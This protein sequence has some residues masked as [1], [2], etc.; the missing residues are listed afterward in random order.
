METTPQILKDLMAYN[1]WANHRILEQ[2]AGLDEGVLSA[3]TR[4]SFDSIVATLYHI[5]DAQIVWYKRLHGESLFSFPHAGKEKTWE[6]IYTELDKHSKMLESFT[7]AQSDDFLMGT[8]TYA[9]TKGT[10]YE[11]P[12]SEIYLQLSHHGNYHRGQIA[13]YIRQLANVKPGQT[14]YILYKRLNS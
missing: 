8:V 11:Q 10:P 9:T 7:N 1:A 14:D 12:V 6:Y 13:S 4:G 5:L 3:Q 2:C